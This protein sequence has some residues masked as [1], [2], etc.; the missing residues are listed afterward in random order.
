MI[1]AYAERMY[2]TAFVDD[3]IG[4]KEMYS[5]AHMEYKAA[6]SVM[7]SVAK[8]GRFDAPVG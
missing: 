8:R 4:I 3:S 2:V 5:N 6:D 7:I 1:S